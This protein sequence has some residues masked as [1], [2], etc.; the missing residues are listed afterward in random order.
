MGGYP[1]AI[2]DNWGATPLEGRFPPRSQFGAWS[3]PGRAL[4]STQSEPR[5]YPTIHLESK[6]RLAD[7]L[8]VLYTTIRSL[9]SRS[10]H[11]RRPEKAKS[12][13]AVFNR[14]LTMGRRGVN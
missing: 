14:P 12:S 3:M 2:P 6:S 11:S 13:Q 7:R 10:R 4:S 8:G 9:K 5:G 1:Y